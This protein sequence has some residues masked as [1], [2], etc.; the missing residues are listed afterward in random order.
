MVSSRLKA[1]QAQ[2]KIG[3]VERLQLVAQQVGVR[4]C[5][6]RQLMIGDPV[7]ALLFLAPAPR[8]DHWNGV[9]LQ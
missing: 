1:G 3:E 4:T 2:I 8:D 5:P 9:Q 7:G 6:R